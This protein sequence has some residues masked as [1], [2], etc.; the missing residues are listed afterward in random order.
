MAINC[1]I[2]ASSYYRTTRT[3]G[4]PIREVKPALVACSASRQRLNVSQSLNSAFNPLIYHEDLVNVRKW[5][6]I[7]CTHVFVFLGFFIFAFLLKQHFRMQDELYARRTQ[8]M[9]DVRHMLK[10]G[11]EDRLKDLRLVDAIQ[12]LGIDH[13]FQEEIEALIWRQHVSAKCCFDHSEGLHEVSLCF[14][15]L[16]QEGYYVPPGGF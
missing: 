14:R 2:L 6:S 9:M 4:A 8:K 3:I 1:T 16:R 13:H 11:G 5:P 12:R 15:L 7:P 10:T